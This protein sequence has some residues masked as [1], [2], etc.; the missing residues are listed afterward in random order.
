MSVKD[1]TP[2]SV[3]ISWETNV[4]TETILN[5]GVTSAYGEKRGITGV[6]K[7]H[8]IKVDSLLDN[9]EYH[10]QIVAKDETGN[11][12]VD[13]DKIIRTP[14][15]TEGPKITNAKVDILPMGESDTTSSIIVSWQTNKPASTQVK[16]GEGILGNDYSNE[17]N[18]DTS[19]NNSHTVIIKGLKPASSYHYKMVSKDRRNNITESQDYT[20]VTPTKEKSILQ[21][22]LKSLEETFAWTGRLNQFFGKLGDRFMGR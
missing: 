9:Q 8:Q 13:A 22:I 14:L 7:A 11:E 12:V 21:L 1:V 10:Y 19:L 18:E 17:S 2:Y 16:Y 4:D 20:F 3:T 5:W 15:D 6:S